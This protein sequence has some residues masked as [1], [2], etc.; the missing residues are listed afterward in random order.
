VTKLSPSLA[1]LKQLD[2]EGLLEAFIL[3]ARPDDG[4]AADYQA[5]LKTN[6]E[7]L[8]RYVTQNVIGTRAQP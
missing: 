4:I 3:M 7:K 1:I 5:Y 2:D 8:R 6:R